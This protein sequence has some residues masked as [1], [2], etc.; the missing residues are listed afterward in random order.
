MRNSE[1]F[2][3][4]L[5]SVLT[6]LI[7]HRAIYVSIKQL[8]FVRDATFPACGEGYSSGGFAAILSP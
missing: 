2:T 1:L 5:I 8:G 7:R 6:R 3:Y 4:S